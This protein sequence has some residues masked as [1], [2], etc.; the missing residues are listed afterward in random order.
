[1]RECDHRIANH[2]AMLSGYV[3]LRERD[4][5]RQLDGA[6][7]A[8]VRLTLQGI[9]AQIE[10]VSRLHRSLTT[11]KQGAEVDLGEHLHQ[12][13]ASFVASLA[14]TIE[15]TEDMHPTCL[16]PSEQILP[17]VQIASEMITNAAK[18][19]A[20][21]IHISLKRQQAKGYA[22][23]VSN[24]GPPLPEGFDPAATKGLGMKIIRSRVAKIGGELSFG[25]GDFDKGVRFTVQFE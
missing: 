8:C 6:T 10:A 14:G 2:L 3:S 11:G 17:L 9:R 15:L 7:A 19:G 16:T 25:A 4:L 13:C 20:K 18:Y 12:M 23:S 5:S 1:V 22:L 24:D 21:R